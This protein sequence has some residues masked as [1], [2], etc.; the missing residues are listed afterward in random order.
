MLDEALFRRFDAVI[1]YEKPTHQEIRDLIS[2]RLSRFGLEEIDLLPSI[3]WAAGLSHAVYVNLAM[4]QRR[5][6]SC[7]TARLLI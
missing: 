2:N 6:P 3:D 1:H 4:M 5:T 7:R